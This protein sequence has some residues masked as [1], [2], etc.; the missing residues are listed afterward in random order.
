VRSAAVTSMPLH[1]VPAPAQ[2]A[3]MRSVHGDVPQDRAVRVLSIDG[4]GVR[5]LVPAIVLAEIEARTGRGVADLFD[6]VAGTSTGA[7]LALGMNVPGERPNV[8]RWQALDCVEFY[9]VHLAEIFGQG[10]W[11]ALAGVAGL[12]REKYDEGPLER[13]MGSY[14][15]DHRLSEALTNVVVPAYDLA[16]SDVM[17]FDSRAA[18]ADGA[19]DLPM[20]LV[21][22]GATAA[23]TYF[24]PQLVSPP[25]AVQQH[26]LVDGGLFANNPGICAFIQAQRLKLGADVV[27]VSLGTGAALRKLRLGEVKSWGLAHWARPLLDIVLGS[28][29]QATDHYLRSLL[30]GQRYFRFEPDLVGH[31]CSHRLDDASAENLVALEQAAKSLVASRSE[32]I[33]LACELLVR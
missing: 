14:F 1:A 32:E 30:G 24:E 18:A 20:R 25:V 7:V 4:G 3:L 19:M 15:A 10:G 12:I 2:G 13:V 21:V 17:L 5:G 29:S 28:G 23:P 31:G 33:D 22:R 11:Q 16:N 9:K 6:V 26:L 27:M 8:P